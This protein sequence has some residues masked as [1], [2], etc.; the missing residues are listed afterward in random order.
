MWQWRGRCEADR[1]TFTGQT[2]CPPGRR[3]PWDS[4]SESE[5]LAVLDQGEV[6]GVG[7]AAAR[8]TA[9]RD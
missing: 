1:F 2:S 7:A 5:G 6:D 4:L 3:R 9:E 8:C